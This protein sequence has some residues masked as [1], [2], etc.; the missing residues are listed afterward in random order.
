M[1]SGVYTVVTSFLLAAAT[2]SSVTGAKPMS[3]LLLSSIHSKVYLQ[4]QYNSPKP[5]TP[6]K[7]KSPGQPTGRNRGAASRG[8][9][10]KSE[11]K[12]PLTALTSIYKEFTVSDRPTLWFYVPYTLSSQNWMQ[13]SLR[14]ESDKSTEPRETKVAIPVRFVPGMIQIQSPY[15]LEVGKE[16]RWTLAFFC[17][18]PDVQADQDQASVNGVIERKALSSKLK[19]QLRIN[20]S[21]PRKQMFLY[22]ENE[23]WFDALNTSARLR[24][25]HS[26]DS[27]LLKNWRRMLKT[28]AVEDI[29]EM[30]LQ[31]CCDFPKKE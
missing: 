5:Y 10:L 22:A 20:Q 18:D 27:V 13:F 31:P 30:P 17:Q 6:P 15:L 16:Y 14:E 23:I 3:E 26:Q 21:N 19:E 24:R 12:L 11:S 8:D 29:S 28:I 4:A 7:P 1:K 25:D 9:C 2:N